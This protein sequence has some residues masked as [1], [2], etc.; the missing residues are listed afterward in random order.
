[1][2]HPWAWRLAPALAGVALAPAFYLFARRMLATR[3]QAVL[4]T[5][6]LL[7]DGVYLVQSRTAM[8]NI[9]AVL[10]QVS[11]A[12]ALVSAALRPRLP[13]PGMALGGLFLGLALSTRWTSLWATAFLGVLLLVLRGRRMVSVR[14]V[15]LVVMTFALIPAALYS[16]SYVPWMR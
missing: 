3:R 10:F 15:A 1:G 9:F 7:C 14:E 12:L 6:L 8:T 4:A 2:Y 13:V 5:V 11:A 16:I